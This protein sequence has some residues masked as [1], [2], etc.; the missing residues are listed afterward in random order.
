MPKSA[1][2][3]RPLQLIGVTFKKSN[4]AT[5][6]ADGVTPLQKA[7]ECHFTLSR[8]G[9]DLELEALVVNDLDVDIFAGIPFYVC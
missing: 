8:D 9:I 3:E 5:L 6:Q 7:G 1:C 4:H 2:L